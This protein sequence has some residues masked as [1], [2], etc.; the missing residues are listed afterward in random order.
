M[1]GAFR[2]QS[3]LYDEVLSLI[4]PKNSFLQ[5]KLGSKQTLSIKLLS[6]RFDQSNKFR[7]KSKRKFR[8]IERM[9]LHRPQTFFEDPLGDILRTSCGRPKSASDQ[10]DS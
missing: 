3:N 1:K 7:K 9:I 5:V 6:Y 10:N 8:D 4:F 2:T